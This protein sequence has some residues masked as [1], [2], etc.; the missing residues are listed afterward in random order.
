MACE[1]EERK[2]QE[3]YFNNQVWVKRRNFSTISYQPIFKMDR[4]SN[5]RV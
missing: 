4:S 2:N 1:K 3:K 5:T